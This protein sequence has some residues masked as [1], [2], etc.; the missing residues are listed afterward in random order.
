MFKAC[1]CKFKVC[2]SIF[3]LEFVYVS[4]SVWVRLECV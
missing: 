3:S 2:S 1:L 4:E